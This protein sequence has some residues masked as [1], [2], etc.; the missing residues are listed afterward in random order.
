MDV[1]RLPSPGS[2][3]FFL[4]QC[5]DRARSFRGV[6]ITI[7][8][9]THLQNTFRGVKTRVG[10]KNITIHTNTHVCVCVDN[11]L[12][13]FELSVWL[14][15]FSELKSENK[16]GKRVKGESVSERGDKKE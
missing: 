8:A 11:L 14:G 1:R 3:V 2:V 6:K 15:F 10:N 7:Q 13:L 5:V 4:C 16:G 9:R 12:A